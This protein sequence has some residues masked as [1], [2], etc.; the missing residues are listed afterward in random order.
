MTAPAAMPIRHR[1]PVALGIGRSN[2]KCSNTATATGEH[3][4]ATI[5]VSGF[6][7]F[8]ASVFDS[9]Q[10][11][12]TKQAKRKGLPF[13]Q[14]MSS[15]SLEG[16]THLIARTAAEEKANWQRRT[17]EAS[18]TCRTATALINSSVEEHAAY[19]ATPAMMVLRGGNSSITYLVGRTGGSF[20]GACNSS[21]SKAAPTT[22]EAGTRQSSR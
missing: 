16:R 11:K 15:M 2:V 5:T 22:S 9:K 12:K 14:V 21:I 10:R 18:F 4:R 7:D 20:S 19:I 6:T 17:K 3:E 13:S 1:V 8:S